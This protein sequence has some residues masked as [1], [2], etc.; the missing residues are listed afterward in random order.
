MRVYSRDRLEKMFESNWANSLLTDQPLLVDEAEA[1]AEDVLSGNLTDAQLGA[2]LSLLRGPQVTGI[3]LAAFAN[4][5]RSRAIKVSVPA[6]SIDTCGTGGGMPSFNISTAAAIVGAAAGIPVAKHGNRAVTSKC[7]SADVLEELGIHLPGDAD[8]ASQM[9]AETGF[10]FMLAP[11]FHPAMKLVGP[12]RKQLWFRTIF[13]LVGPLSSPSEIRRQVLGVYDSSLLR[14]VAEALARIG[15]DRALAVNGD[16]MDEFTPLGKNFVFRIEPDRLEFIEW[17]P[18]VNVEL[19][20][21]LP[22]DSIAANAELLTIAVTDADSGRS[23]AIL[24]SVAAALFV[25]G[26]VESL[27]EGI[28]AGEEVI[29][30]GKAG[31]KLTQ[32]QQW[33]ASL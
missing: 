22:A 10:A 24:P 6:G 5:L 7:G 33:S 21:V 2:T 23:R 4:G 14:Q 18:E 3:V 20:D 28:S 13:N 9:L 27:D 30:S 16:G 25:G 29:R 8:G 15:V 11:T 31:A 19:E 1:M 12:V 32:L 17:I 26:V